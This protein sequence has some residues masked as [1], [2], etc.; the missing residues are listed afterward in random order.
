[1]NKKHVTYMIIAA[2]MF[3][4]IILFMNITGGNEKKIAGSWREIEEDGKPGE[5]MFTFDKNGNVTLSDNST[6]M[7][8]TYSINGGKEMIMNLN[9]LWVSVTLDADVKIKGDRLILTDIVSN[10]DE[11]SGQTLTYERVK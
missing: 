8:G 2:V 4:L 5:S 6:S 7:A 3:I 10:L 11:L 1:M 9:Y